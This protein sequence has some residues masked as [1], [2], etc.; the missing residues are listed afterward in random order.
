MSKLVKKRYGFA[1]CQPSSIARVETA[2]QYGGR[3]LVVKLCFL[4]ARG[5]GRE[6]SDSAPSMATLDLKVGGVL[7]LAFSLEQI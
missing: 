1:V 6:A 3:K 5:C 7:V 2:H 4:W